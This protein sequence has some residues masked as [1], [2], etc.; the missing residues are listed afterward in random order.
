[1]PN[2][3]FAHY[4]PLDVRRNRKNVNLLSS[5]SHGKVHK[6]MIVEE[7]SVF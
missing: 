4:L 6:A 7:A 2:M 1:M 3:W 5:I